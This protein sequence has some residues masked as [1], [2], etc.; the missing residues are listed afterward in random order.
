VPIDS[1]RVISN[2]ATGETGILL[3]EKLIRHGAK[4]TLLLGPVKSCCLN[5]EIKLLSFRFFDELKNKLIKEIK[6]NNYD[7]VIHSAAVSD[8]RLQKVF[9]SKV[10]SGKNKWQINLVPAEKIIDSIKKADRSLLLVGFKF[11]AGL[12][13][14][15]LVK[16]ARR[17]IRRAKADLV[18]ANTINN[19][20]YSAYLVQR[21]KTIGPWHRKEKMADFLVN[22]IG[23][24][25]C[26]NRIY[27]KN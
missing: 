6:S 21:N 19:N 9:V 24:E 10:R 1:V 13:K 4:V 11:E 8:Y 18:I 3:A 26:Q 7:A 20:R 27:R 17:L 12:N 5:K 22:S 2:T 23:A 14:A 15:K 16:K 25:L